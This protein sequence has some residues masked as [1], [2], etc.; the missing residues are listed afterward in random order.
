MVLDLALVA[1]Y[2]ISSSLSQQLSNSLRTHIMSSS[3]CAAT[4]WNTQDVLRVEN[5]G[6]CIGKTLRDKECCCIVA[7]HNQ[8][9]A[10]HLMGTLSKR[11]PDPVTL[12]ADLYQLASLLLCRR[13]H[14]NQAQNIV[15]KWD[16]YLENLRESQS[17]QG[18]S[19]EEE[20]DSDVE[21]TPEPLLV[22]QSL[23]RPAEE[24]STSS[25]QSEQGVPSEGALESHEEELDSDEDDLDTDEGDL[26]EPSSSSSVA[27]SAIT[28][29]T[30]RHVRRR[31]IDDSCPICQE[32]YQVS[33]Q[34]QLVWCKSRC[35]RTVHKACFEAWEASCLVR[36][37][38]VT[39]VICRTP[40]AR[41]CACE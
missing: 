33:D 35:G 11:S 2:R 1:L 32:D 18:V 30:L 21:E 38:T 12:E 5:M 7:R 24:S 28:P 13:F 14:Q 23:I 40:W 17:E 41:D 29:C 37:I 31:A 4:L 25:S 36:G 9:K 8:R 27:T 20:L 10:D 16:T 3:T 19:S 34:N 26:E 15:D 22:N 39:C 6:R